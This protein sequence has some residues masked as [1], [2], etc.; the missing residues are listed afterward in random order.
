MAIPV[1]C[2][3]EGESVRNGSLRAYSNVRMLGPKLLL[4]IHS[5]LR[6]SKGMTQAFEAS[7]I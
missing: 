5:P 6:F 2:E 4:T 1:R 3:P 7:D